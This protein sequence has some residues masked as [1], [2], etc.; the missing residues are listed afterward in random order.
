VYYKIHK[1]ITKSGQHFKK[2]K[3]SYKLCKLEK[4]CYFKNVLALTIS[5]SALLQ[6]KAELLCSCDPVDGF[7]LLSTSS[8]QPPPRHPTDPGTF[9]LPL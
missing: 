7:S 3:K 9:L 2:K 4:Y 6:M 5:A 8:S 1:T